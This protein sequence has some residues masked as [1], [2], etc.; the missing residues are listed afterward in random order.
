MRRFHILAF[1]ELIPVSLQ[2]FYTRSRIAPFLAKVDQLIIHAVTSEVN[3]DLGTLDVAVQHS[4][5]GR[6]WIDK[7]VTTSALLLTGVE[8]NHVVAETGT[9]PSLDLVRLAFRLNPPTTTGHVRV[10]VT[11]RDTRR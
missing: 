9:A 10:H 4:S 2:W 5:D 6:N 3:V 1:D 7:G 8:N 11:G